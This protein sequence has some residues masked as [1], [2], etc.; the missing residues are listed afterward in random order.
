MRYAAIFIEETKKF[1]VWSEEFCRINGAYKVTGYNGD[2]A[3]G[4][5]HHYDLRNE[6]VSMMSSVC[7]TLDQL[8][9]FDDL[10][11]ATMIAE[12]KNYSYNP[13]VR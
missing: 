1:E 2:A 4:S 8:P 12:R 11:T 7:W 5:D 6:D 13:T 9:E 3:F 10:E